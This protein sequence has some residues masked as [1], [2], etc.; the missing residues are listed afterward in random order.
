MVE[1]GVPQL[2]ELQ[3]PASVGV[4][5]GE[6]GVH[7]RAELALRRLAVQGEHRILLRLGRP[8][9]RGDRSLEL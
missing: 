5:R 6:G 1:A 3:R 8:P 2:A 9:L 4:N 7:R